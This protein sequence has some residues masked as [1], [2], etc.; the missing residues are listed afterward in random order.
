MRVLVHGM[1]AQSSITMKAQIS[2]LL[3]VGRDLERHPMVVF[4]DGPMHGRFQFVRAVIPVI[5]TRKYRLGARRKFDVLAGSVL[6]SNRPVGGRSV[7]VYIYERCRCDHICHMHPVF[8]YHY[9]K[10]MWARVKY[11]KK[12][13]NS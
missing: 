7:Q 6:Y 12:R 1:T 8:A 10:T 2:G 5:G 11:L 3:E 4:V 13:V 9:R